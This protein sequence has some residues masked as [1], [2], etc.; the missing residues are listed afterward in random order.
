MLG[1]SI[2][3]YTLIN[4][5]CTPD[6]IPE[7]KLSQGLFGYSHLYTAPA[8]RKKFDDCVKDLIDCS[9][10]NSGKQKLIPKHLEVCLEQRHNRSEL[11]G[12]WIS[13]A[14]AI[15]AMEYK[16]EDSPKPETQQAP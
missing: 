15:F 13:A 2:S 4:L 1:A 7:T 5:M 6:K 12:K 10:E 3:I 8:P 14:E 16:A 9:R 11:R